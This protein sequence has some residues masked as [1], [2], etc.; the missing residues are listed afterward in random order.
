MIEG[1]FLNKPSISIEVSHEQPKRDN[2]SKSTKFHYF[3]LLARSATSVTEIFIS[4]GGVR[5]RV[6]PFVTICARVSPRVSR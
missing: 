3:R 4:N 2:L 5:G 6:S 1:N